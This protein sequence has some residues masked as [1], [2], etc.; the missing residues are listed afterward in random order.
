MPLDRRYGVNSSENDKYN[1]YSITVGELL[2]KVSGWGL[3]L[4]DLDGLD[5]EGDAV[6]ALEDDA[7]GRLH[8]FRL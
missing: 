5:E 4:A 2:S 7:V 1:R 6:V 8:S 3:V